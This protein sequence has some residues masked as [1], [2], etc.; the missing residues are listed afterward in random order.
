MPFTL[1]VIFEGVCAFVPSEPLFRNPRPTEHLRQMNVLLPDLRLPE[2]AYWDREHHGPSVFWR[3]PHLAFLDVE[4]ESLSS[5]TDAR[6]DLDWLERSSRRKRAAFF[7]D[8]RRLRVEGGAGEP[9]HVEQIRCRGAVP[10][11]PEEQRSL[12]WLPRMSEIAPPFEW[13]PGDALRADRGDLPGLAGSVQILE[14]RIYVQDYNRRRDNDEIQPWSFGPVARD[15]EGELV[16]PPEDRAAWNRAI[17]NRIVWE[18]AI[19]ES[20]TF[21]LTDTEGRERSI[22]VRPPVGSDG[23][24]IEVRVANAEPEV[25]LLG[26]SPLFGALLEPLPDPDFQ[27]YYRLASGEVEPAEAHGWAVPLAPSNL[28]G[29]HE[30]PCSPA[31]FS[32]FAED[33]G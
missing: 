15:A 19:E 26:A 17:G 4:W 22:V 24:P 21:K 33:E 30:K 12:W 6:I 2:V 3:A 31:L 25:G 32:G 7:F 11:T 27:V 8:Q 20:A 9:L 13:F 18:L 16:L 5:K 1:R 28:F 23:A 14:G 29:Q 10:A